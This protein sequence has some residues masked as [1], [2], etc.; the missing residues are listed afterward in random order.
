MSVEFSSRWRPSGLTDLDIFVKGI[1]IDGIADNHSHF[2]SQ[3]TVRSKRAGSTDDRDIS[4][5]PHR[6][7]GRVV[8]PQFISEAGVNGVQ[9]NRIPDEDSET[10]ASWI[11][12]SHLSVV[13]A[14][15]EILDQP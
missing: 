1:K 14:G 8:S 3:D 13:I 12:V 9:V 11:T 2:F 7:I 10:V 5:N 4:R 6:M 15:F